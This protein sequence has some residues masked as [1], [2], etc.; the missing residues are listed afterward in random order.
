MSWQRKPSGILLP[1]VITYLSAVSK[2]SDQAAR[3]NLPA[4]VEPIYAVAMAAPPEFAA[5]ALL[6]LS[7]RVTDLEARRGLIEMAFRL[8]AVRLVSFPGADVDTRSGSLSGALS[9]R[10]DALSLQSQGVGHM[11]AVDRCAHGNCSNR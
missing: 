2:G 7:P 3:P 6:C 1:L 8:A 10:L 4:E 9:L 5:R 11:V